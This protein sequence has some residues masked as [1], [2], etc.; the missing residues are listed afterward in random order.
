MGL[1]PPMQST[2]NVQPTQFLQIGGMV[3]ADVLADDEEYSEVRWLAQVSGVQ[4]EPQYKQTEV[5]FP[6]APHVQH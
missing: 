2:P 1:P 5:H 4:C 6:A 3:T